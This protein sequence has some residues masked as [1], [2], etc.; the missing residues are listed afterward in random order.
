MAKV[1]VHR[2]DIRIVQQGVLSK[3]TSDTRL[4]VSTE[5]HIRV[6]L[7]ETIDPDGT[8]LEL[9]SSLNS[10]VDVLGEY[11]SSETVDSVVGLL[12]DVVVILELDDHTNGAEDLLLN[13]PHVGFRLREDGR[14]DEISFAAYALAS[15][16]DLS[17]LALPE[18]MYP[19]MRSYWICETCGPWSMSAPNGSPTRMDWAF[20]VNFSR[21]SS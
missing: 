21:N 17:T 16:V 7:V 12:D 2:L 4:F 3:L 1:Y 6:E 14:G 18:S 8:S 13:D 11:S 19:M 9:V 5:G 10:A 15:K 20:A